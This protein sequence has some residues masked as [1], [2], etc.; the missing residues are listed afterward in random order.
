MKDLFSTLQYPV[1]LFDSIIS[2]SDLSDKDCCVD[3]TRIVLL[4]KDHKSADTVRRQLEDS[5]DKIGKKLH[6]QYSQVGK[7]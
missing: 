4:F 1:S 7:N 2:V 3:S 6:G 5:S